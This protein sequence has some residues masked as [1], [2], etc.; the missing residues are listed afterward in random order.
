MA[1]HTLEQ[2]ARGGIQDHLAGGFCRYSVDE[3][4]M[5]PHFEK[6][7][8]DNG[9]LLAVYA[10]AW[11]AA[12]RRPLFRHVCERTAEWVMREMQAADGGYYASLDADSEGEEGRFYVWDRTEVKGLL[13]ADEYRVFAP[14]YGLDRAAN[15]EGRWHLHTHAATAALQAATGLDAAAVRR[16][17]A[18]ARDK[19]LAARGKRVRPA[20]DDKIL[21]AW[22]GLM[23]KGMAQAGRILNEQPYLDSA[24]A[25][26]RFIQTH[27][28]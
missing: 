22:N 7:L 11:I 21:T 9:Q 15:F 18:S 8:Y 26:T 14:R 6:M 10:E 5:I 1:F 20:C 12:D 28:L 23:I 17:L 24:L 27:G 2:M 3:Q 13:N 19:L 16:R 4:W 25:A